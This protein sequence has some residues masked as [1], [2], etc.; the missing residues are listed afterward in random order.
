MYK[1]ADNLQA[2]VCS[3]KQQIN[4]Q[5]VQDVGLAYVWC[6]AQGRRAGA[7]AKADLIQIYKLRSAG[8]S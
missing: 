2:D 3:I 8:W 7:G 1:Y 5:G 6:R 4:W